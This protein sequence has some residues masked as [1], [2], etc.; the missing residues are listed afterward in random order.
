M[1][2]SYNGRPPEQA[3]ATTRILD[4]THYAAGPF[5]TKLLADYGAEVIKVERPGQGDPGRR[6]GPFHDDLP[7]PDSSAL[8]QFLNQNKLG[9]TLDLKRTAGVRLFERLVPWAD[10]IV[11]SFRP[12]VMSSFG[13]G[14]SRLK[15]LNPDVVLTSISNFGQNGPYKDRKATEIVEYATGGPMLF[16][17][18]ALRE[19]LKHGGQ[20]G[21]YFAGQVAAIA[22]LSALYRQM[23]NGGSGTTWTYR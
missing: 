14:Y 1:S 5:C 18:A 8:F 9:V 17:G 7:A 13:L 4:L 23:G 15:E 16:T 10:I 12:G 11:E 20:V 3:L 22:T 2:E 6:L 19:P 21:M